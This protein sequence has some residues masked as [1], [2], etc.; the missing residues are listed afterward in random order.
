MKNYLFLFFFLEVFTCFGQ[1]PA[2]DPNWEPLPYFSDDFSGSNL[3]LSKWKVPNEFDHYG[4]PVIFIDNLNNVHLD[5][6]GNLVLELR[7]EEYT[8]TT[9]Q[10][11]P[12]AN[13]IFMTYQ[14]TTPG[15]RV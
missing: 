6:Y 14:H 3:D 12:D 4:E 11:L 2:D 5:G 13:G 9:S 7:Q 10:G 15:S 1:T 8:P